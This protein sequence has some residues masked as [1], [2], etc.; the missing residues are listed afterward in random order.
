[1]RGLLEVLALAPLEKVV[2]HLG[3]HADDPSFEQLSGA[4]DAFLEAGGTLDEV[5]VVLAFAIAEEFPAAAHC[6]GLLAARV[7]F[8]LPEVPQAASSSVLAAP[9][10]V[11][12]AIR[13]LRR[14]RREEEK[15]KKAASVT[16]APSRARPKS[17]APP[18][19]SSAPVRAAPVEPEMRR[20]PILTPLEESRFDAGHALVG[21]LVLIDV[22]FDAVDPAQPEI[23]SKERPALVVGVGADALLVRALYSNDAPS[24]SPFSAWRRAGLDHPSFI[25]DAR[26]V[27]SVE[28][29]TI[30]SLAQLS[31]AEWNSLF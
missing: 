23:S 14:Q 25:E 9:R 17:V 10:E 30:R 20:R 2:E 29:L 28:V 18:R 5:L 24:R 12:P 21:A 27:V 4:I 3:E 16:R 15:K 8:A 7:A 1:V 19:V 13:E 11:N 22:P 6:R 31:V 26:V